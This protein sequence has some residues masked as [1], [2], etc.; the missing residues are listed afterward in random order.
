MFL[1]YIC[2]YVNG[3]LRLEQW[4][5]HYLGLL[6]ENRTNYTVSNPVQNLTEANQVIVKEVERPCNLK[7]K[8]SSCRAKG[9]TN[10]LLKYE[11]EY[12]LTLLTD[13]CN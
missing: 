8:Q 11:G 9:D 2:A 10:E 1:K 12:V 7:K 5:F 4:K 6:Q 3:P 13:I